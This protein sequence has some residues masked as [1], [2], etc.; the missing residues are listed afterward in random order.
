M[1]TKISFTHDQLEFL[2]DGLA[3]LRKH[4]TERGYKQHD[5]AKISALRD[6]LKRALNDSV[7]CQTGA[8]VGRCPDCDEYHS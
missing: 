8:R 4:L 1:R 6:H 3:M 2:V 7:P 5:D